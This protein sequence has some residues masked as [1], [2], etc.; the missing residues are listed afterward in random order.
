M[1]L[2]FHS[3]LGT[4]DLTLQYVAST[5]KYAGIGMRPIEAQTNVQVGIF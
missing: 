2:L 3:G 4:L 1:R 5:D